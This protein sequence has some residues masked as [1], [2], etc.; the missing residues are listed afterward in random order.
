MDSEILDFCYD[1]M[2]RLGDS[3]NSQGPTIGS[4]GEVIV[5]GI[6]PT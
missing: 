1:K 3:R 2:T 4:F 5:V 6:P